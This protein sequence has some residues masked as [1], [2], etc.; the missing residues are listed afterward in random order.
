MERE[1]EKLA[2]YNDDT[3]ITEKQTIELCK[4][5]DVLTIKEL[6]AV[7]YEDYPEVLP[8]RSKTHIQYQ[9]GASEALIWQEGGTKK[10]RIPW[11]LK[12]GGWF[13][14]DPVWGLP[15][16]KPSNEKDKDALRLWR[17]TDRA[18]SGLLVRDGGFVF[19][20]GRGVGADN[21]PDF[22]CGVLAWK[23]KRAQPASSSDLII[24][25]REVFKCKKHG[26]G[27]YIS[28]RKKWI[29]YDIEC[30]VIGKSKRKK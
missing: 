10:T 5:K 3:G 16:G 13:Q 23:N 27:A 15:I 7:P 6:M 17:Y 30:V 14:C 18:Y 22:R 25:D 4:Q 8:A 21:G 19:G 26:N 20:L 29:G 24:G 11:P 28:G 2:V 1:I 9:A 12:N